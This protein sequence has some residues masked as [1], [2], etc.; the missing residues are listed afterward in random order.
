MSTPVKPNDLDA[1]WMP[2]TPNR[3]YKKNPRMLV[4]AEGMFYTSADGR[5]LIDFNAGL[6]CVNAG[7]N[8][9][10]ITEAIRKQAGELDYAPN[11]Q[12]S[13]PLAF[14]AA[15]ALCA[16]MPGTLDNVFFSCSGSEAVDTALKIALAYQRARG[17]ATKTKFIGRERGYN[18]VGFGG[19]SVGG[20]SYNRKVFA[21]GL[22]P[23]C[24]HLPHTHNLAKNA[25]SKGLPEHGADL[26]DV[27]ENIIQL[28]DAENVAAVI[29]EPVAGSTG[30]LP[31]PK[32]YLKRLR[33][34]CDKYDV[35]LIFDEVITAWGRLGYAS[36]SE[37]YGVTPDMITSAKGI[38]NGTVPMGATFVSS[39][40]Y[41]TMTEGSSDVIDFM[42]GYTYSGHPLACAAALA[43]LDVYKSE[44]LFERSQ[45]MAPLWEQALHS[46]K[47]AP[48]VIDIRN[49]GLMGG[50][51]LDPGARQPGDGPSRALEV[52]NK[53]FFEQDMVMRFTA[54]TLA[55]SPPLIV[56]E[57]QLH[58]MADKIR[59]VLKTVA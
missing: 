27:L 8:H 51:E 37:A 39:G 14:Q 58:M 24:D 40:I 44:G 57:D 10:K 28:H 29:V 16:E 47:D 3:S 59:A 19:I 46:L 36:A 54:N 17:K 4:G 7:H 53:L 55:A 38:N 42:H 9:P 56:E 25:F 1:F 13:H 33:E 18:G 6:W 43:T 49:V 50:I 20:I 45:K 32:G 41:K 35:L 23:N 21:G 2:F 34:I 12:L 5:K 11:F 31:P 30:V 26:A 15:T 48:H 22:L 52:F